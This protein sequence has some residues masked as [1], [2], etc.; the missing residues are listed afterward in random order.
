MCASQLYQ[1]LLRSFTEYFA[2]VLGNQDAV[3]DPDPTVPGNIYA[4]LDRHDITRQQF[5][6]GDFLERRRLVDVKT[7]AVT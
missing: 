5:L 7:D 2:T 1:F 3:L 6:I 4:R